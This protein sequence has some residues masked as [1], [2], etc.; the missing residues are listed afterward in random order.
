MIKILA[1]LALLM[2]LFLSFATFGGTDNIGP[3]QTVKSA[4]VSLEKNQ[5]QNFISLLSGDARAVYGTPTGVIALQRALSGLNLKAGN[6]TLLSTDYD[7][8][9]ETWSVPVNTQENP[10][11]LILTTQLTCDVGYVN[12]T[13]SK[14]CSIFSIVLED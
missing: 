10:S 3:T 12:G 9:K 1:L 6:G 5:T 7:N 4:Y 13:E 2:T 11:T 8:D 14:T